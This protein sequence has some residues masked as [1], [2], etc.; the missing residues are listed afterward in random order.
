MW[1]YLKIGSLRRNLKLNDVIEWDPNP[2]KLVFLLEDE[3]T[4][5]LTLS[6]CG[7]K[8]KAMLGHSE[9]AVFKPGRESSVETNCYNTL[10][11]DSSLQNC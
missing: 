1:L 8:R 11:L 4:P 7:H 6:P 2:I 9:E 10:I 3:K 5:E